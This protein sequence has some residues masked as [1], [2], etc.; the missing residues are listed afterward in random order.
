MRRMLA[1]FAGGVA[2]GVAVSRILGRRARAKLAPAAAPQAPPDPRAEELR[3]RLEHAR[4]AEPAAEAP[5]AG[6]VGPEVE[7]DE[8]RRRVHERGRAAVEAMRG[9]AP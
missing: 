2:L 1:L 7:L 4:A 6:E 5:A 9:K 8:A 3:R